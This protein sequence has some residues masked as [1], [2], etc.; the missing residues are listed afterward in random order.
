MQTHKLYL[1]QSSSMITKKTTEEV[2]HI[3]TVNVH[4]DIALLMETPQ[5]ASYCNHNL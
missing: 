5:I 2:L 3:A 1:L 4:L